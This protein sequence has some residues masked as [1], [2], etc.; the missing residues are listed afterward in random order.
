MCYQ[1]IEVYGACHCLYYQHPVDRCPFYGRPGHSVQQRTTTL[2]GWV[3][4]LHSTSGQAFRFPTADDEA[5]DNS[6]AAVDGEVSKT[7]S[8]AGREPQPVKGLHLAGRSSDEFAERL[9]MD[10]MVEPQ[11]KHLLPQ[12]VRLSKTYLVAKR[13][14]SRFLLRFSEDLKGHSETTLQIEAAEHIG[15][16]RSIMARRIVDLHMIELDIGSEHLTP[17]T[18][19]RVPQPLDTL[20]TNGIQEPLRDSQTQLL[21]DDATDFLFTGPPFESFQKSIKEFVEKSEPQHHPLF[22]GGLTI[23]S[24]LLS[25]LG[26][27]YHPPSSGRKRLW[28]TCVSRSLRF[29]VCAN[30][31]RHAVEWCMMTTRNFDPV[32]SKTWRSFSRHVD[33]RLLRQSVLHLSICWLQSSLPSSMPCSLLLQSLCRCHT[34]G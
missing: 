19:S 21:Y 20:S 11:L 31:G 4:S 12:V 29:Q 10:F 3:C 33:A 8:V 32:P 22:D 28:W 14:L 9:I 18:T 17:Q 2:A 24:N 1:A 23:G 6:K 27:I 25:V 13:H 16:R 5:T 26:G 30:D 34:S 7:A 15:R